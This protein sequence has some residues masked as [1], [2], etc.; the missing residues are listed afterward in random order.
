MS[1]HLSSVLRLVAQ[2]Q[3]ALERDDRAALVDIVT[4][5]VAM[6]ASMG[7]QWRSLAELAASLG[8]LNLFH[9]ALDLL[10]EQTGGNNAAKY[11]KVGLLAE[12]G[13]WQKAYELL[14]TLPQDVPDLA[15]NAYGRGA[16][17]VNLGQPAEAR[18]YL[19]RAIDMRPELGLPW[20]V[21][22]MSADLVREPNLADRI[23]AAEPG[24]AK[25]VPAQYAPYCYALGNAHAVRGEHA[26]AF[27]AFARGSALTSAAIGFDRAADRREA[28]EAIRGYTAP[29]IGAI[30]REQ[31]EP[32]GRTIFVTGLP[33]SGTTLVQQILTGHS[34]VS[35][36]AET[37]RLS[38]LAREVGGPSCSALE[39][40]G[41]AMGTA[42]A[43]RLWHHWLDEMFPGA[44]RVV[45][46]T[47]TTSRYLGLAA[48][49]LP[50]AP[51]IWLTRDPLDRAWSCFR[52]NF[53]GGAM[54]WSY[55]LED[56]A[57]HFRLED[58]LLARWHELL[59][60]R[61][62]VVPYEGLVE[63]SSG[64]IRRILAHCGLPEEPQ[65]FAPHENPLHV[66]TASMM[67]VRR[68]INRDA[69]G[70]AQPYREFLGPF[71]DAYYG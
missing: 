17:L 68:P 19:D 29:R 34:L 7:G 37:N 52:T 6:R 43:A 12:L 13:E 44:E 8:E 22:T 56:I 53:L 32:T 36:G 15:G 33:R 69:I 39:R 64:W 4:Q 60:G 40:Y 9:R 66:G 61:L 20:L 23:I 2:L 5:L 55:D 47:V 63:D 24:I 3:P 49:L 31:R 18:E 58:E 42:P 70:S 21:L 51:L 25:D 11:Q 38:L 1:E 30:A 46:K 54:P 62:L 28:A 50:E 10:V 14:C 16:A 41:A 35:D 65:T 45:D 57:F 71:I 67:Q 48:S 59:G 26:L 27:A